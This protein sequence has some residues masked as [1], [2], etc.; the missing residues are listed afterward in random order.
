MIV[1]TINYR[2]ATASIEVVEGDSIIESSSIS[3]SFKY[4]KVVAANLYIDSDSKNVF[5]A[6]SVELTDS[7]SWDITTGFNDSISLVDSPA[8]LM[9]AD[10][11]SPPI[12]LSDDL[13]FAC[14]YKPSF[15]DSVTLSDAPLIS[16][17]LNIGN[18]EVTLTDS[19]ELIKTTYDS[20]VGG[21][22]INEG[23]IN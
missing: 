21:A 9:T 10:F 14:L 22:A 20:S 6:D 4:R 13:S 11:I 3:A 23:V 5:F 18:S 7:M 15:I 16:V 8:F 1:Y 17:G 2:R 12:V 19:L